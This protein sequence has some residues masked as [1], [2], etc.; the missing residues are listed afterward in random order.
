MLRRDSPLHVSPR[1]LPTLAPWLWRFWRHCNARDYERGLNAVAEL[2]GATMRLYDAWAADGVAFE[3]H[4]SGLLFTFLDRNNLPGAMADIARLAPYGYAT[5]APLIGD[6]LRTLEPALSDNVNAGFLLESERHVRPETLTAGLALRL[7]S[8]GVTMESGTEVHGGFGQG[9]MLRALRT[10]HGE[11]AADQFLI[12][13]GIWSKRLAATLG[14]ALPIE[15]GKGY[16]VTM[17]DPSLTLR[18]PLYLGESK[19][20]VSPF[21]DGIRVA[22]TMELSGLNSRLDY[23]RVAALQQS[24]ERFLRARPAWE[25]G[26]AWVGPRPIVPD[27]LPMIGRLPGYENVYIATGHAMLGVTLAPATAELLADMM[28]G[29]PTSVDSTPFDPARFRR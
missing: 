4:H 18:R 19:V 29:K 6:E 3:M 9:R 14:A 7:E 23:R 26:E 16:S 20:G 25:R 5:P 21:H 12:A 11:L 15:A 13:A 1:K 10:S 28:D 2:N 24:S 17:A 8:L 27:G 22:G